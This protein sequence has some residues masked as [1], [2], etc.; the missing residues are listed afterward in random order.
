MN[1]SSLIRQWQSQGQPLQVP[2]ANS[3]IWR[4]GQGEPV[5]CMHGVPASGF[6]Y[7]KV[8]PELE[9][10]GFEGV[11]LDLPGLGL[12][13]R[14]VQFDYSWSGLSAWYA[15]ALD[16]AGITNFHLVV[17]DVGGPIGFD[18][19]RRLP[20]R[21]KSLT[22]LNTMVNVSTFHKPW[23]MVP[24]AWPVIGRL[25]LQSARTPLFHLL[26]RLQGMHHISREESAAYG[27]LLLGADQGRAFQQI[28]R[29]FERT[30]AFEQAIKSALNVR[31]FPAQ[32]IW[33]KDDPA[34]RVERYAPELMAALGL[35]SFQSVNGK[36]FLQEDA[37]CEIAEAVARLA[38]S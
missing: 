10:R 28:M 18:L 16:A 9:K 37:Y 24:F 12:A 23:S 36:H 3:W 13:D 4:S 21:I 2:G 25:W 15:S 35:E 1:A 31:G 27:Q 32:I 38:R 26:M 19:I 8:L 14:P 6:L 11:T 17:H 5:V 34:L 29:S 30:E 22:V 20:G 7:R 33:G